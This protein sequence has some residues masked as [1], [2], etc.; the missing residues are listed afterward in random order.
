M[1]R[2]ATLGIALASGLM[3]AS[4]A[5]AQEA[6]YLYRTIDA[7][8]VMR[9]LA[10][11]GTAHSVAREW[12][13]VLLEAIRHDKARP[14]VH[15]RNLYHTS[16]AMWDAWA[17]YDDTADQVFH[18]ERQTAGDV[19]AAREE[20][21]SYAMYRMM[22]HRFTG[23]VGAAVTLPLIEA[24]MTYD[25][26]VTTLIGDTPAALGNRIAD[27]IITYGASDGANEANDYE[28][29]WYTAVNDPLFP[30]FPGN[31]DISDPNRWQPLAIEFF[32]D[33]SGNPIPLGSL[34]FLSPEWGIV[35][36][37]A[38]DPGDITM[39]P[40][41][42]FPYPVCHDPGPPPL[43]NG[44]GDDYYRWGNEMVVV[45]S[46]HLDPTDGVN[47]DI[48][49]NSFGNS[50]LPGVNDWATYYDFFNGGDSGT[51][52]ATNPVTGLPYPQQVVPRGD[53]A[54]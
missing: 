25:T 43:F 46:S 13:E 29:L 33:Q 10:P 9:D 22:S 45:W 23:S 15:A 31:P 34:E 52:W 36:G 8:G 39:H 17:A 27:T 51:G 5:L 41:E 48:S 2:T 37:F 32:V 18:I 12:N 20:A 38:I 24:Q 3:M 6:G 1:T 4:P 7:E 44:V 11:R 26:G 30:D 47:I 54:R 35:P 49:P 16:A 28:N 40:R 19:Q 53:Y 50:P 42:G 21:I 14:T